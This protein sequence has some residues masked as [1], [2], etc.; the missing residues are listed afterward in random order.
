MADLL[1]AIG[2]GRIYAIDLFAFAGG[3]KGHGGTCWTSFDKTMQPYHGWFEKVEGDSTSIHWNRSIDLLFI[4]GDHGEAGVL[5]DIQKY[6]PFIRRGEGVFLHD[7]DEGTDHVITSRV[8]PVVERTLLR[9][10]RYRRIGLV[11]SLIA[12]KKVAE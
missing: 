8:K 12:F 10:V 11:G 7:Y 6:T 3:G 2:R 5:A 1:K 9:D 4:D